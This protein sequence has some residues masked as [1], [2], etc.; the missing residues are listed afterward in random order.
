MELRQAWGANGIQIT[1]ARE[2]C[3]AK[4][5]SLNGAKSMESYKANV[6]QV[7]GAKICQEE[8][9]PSQGTKTMEPK[10]GTNATTP[11]QNM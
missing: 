9:I 5:E 3:Q 10:P 2:L 8:S 1:A 11:M 6:S 4:G 7:Q